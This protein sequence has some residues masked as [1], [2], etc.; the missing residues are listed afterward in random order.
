MINCM[1]AWNYQQKPSGF[2]LN[3]EVI[4]KTHKIMM[5]DEKDV[6]AGNIESHLCLR[7]IM[8][9]HQLVI[10]KDIWKA[11]FLDFIK[12]KKMIQLWSP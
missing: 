4:K 8:L 11:Q 9:L 10:L 6:L 5:Q 12:L 1:K 7:V 2:P 3:T